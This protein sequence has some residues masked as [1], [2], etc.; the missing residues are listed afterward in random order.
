MTSN[1]SVTTVYN[2]FIVNIKW[3]NLLYIE[4]WYLQ[5]RQDN[6]DN[7]YVNII[8]SKPLSTYLFYRMKNIKNQW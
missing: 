3:H 4:D 5:L 8:V 2:E 6:I 7:I 1:R